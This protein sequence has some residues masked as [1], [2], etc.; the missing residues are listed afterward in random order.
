MQIQE[1]SIDSVMMYQRLFS[2]CFPKSMMSAEYIN[3]LYFENPLGNAVGFDAI[4]GNE[5][6]SHYACIPIRINGVIGLLSVN[7]ATHPNFRS[8]GL[9]KKLA[10]KTYEHWNKDFQ[11]VVGVANA[12]S[13]KTFVKH[14]GFTEIGKLNL[15]YG[16]LN[17][18]QIG[19]RSWTSEEI[20][21]R[22]NCPRQKISKESL[23]TGVILLSLRPK[24]FPF[25][26]K[27]LVFISDSQKSEIRPGRSKKRFGFTVDWIRDSKF[28]VQLPEQLKPSPL[29]LIFQSFGSV[30]VELS[31]WTFSDFD[32]F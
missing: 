5:V 11:F 3:W 9:Y 19:S 13:S 17:R 26:L 6:V 4:D 28:K 23:S 2:V 25:K 18:T 8:Q 12:Q 16:A 29:V 1:L 32:I 27:S 21:W 30:N 15:R 22:I 14:L 7:T 20:E 31:S 10:K 24:N